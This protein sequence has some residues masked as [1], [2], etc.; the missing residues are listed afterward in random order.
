MLK[1]TVTGYH[2][3]KKHRNGDDKHPIKILAVTIMT[4]TAKT[5]K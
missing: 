2:R 3:S 1:R 4:E 5:G